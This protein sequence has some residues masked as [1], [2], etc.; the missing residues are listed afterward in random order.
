MKNI[1]ILFGGAIWDKDSWFS[2]SGVYQFHKPIDEVDGLQYYF[3]VGASVYFWNFDFNFSNQYSST[4]LGVQGYLGL[5]YAFEDMPIN[6]TLD[7]IPTIF[8]NS[9]GFTSGFAAGYGTLGVR[10]ILSR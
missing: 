9:G 3:G 8:V 6:V 10:Y 5:D 1:K 7:W 2:V 4:T